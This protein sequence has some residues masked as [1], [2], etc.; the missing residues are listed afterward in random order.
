MYRLGAYEDCITKAQEFI[1]K[2]YNK[3]SAAI[4]SNFMAKTK[5]QTDKLLTGYMDYLRAKSLL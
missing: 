3:L 4:F 2:P 1:Q 5:S